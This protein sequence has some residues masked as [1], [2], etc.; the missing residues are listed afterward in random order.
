MM[1]STFQVKRNPWFQGVSVTADGTGVAALAGTAAVRLLADRV[2]LTAAL[3]SALARRNF[4]PVHD[5]GQVLVDVATVL[6]AGG[7]AIADIDTLRHQPL[8]GPVPSLATVW[9]PFD[10]ITP[11]ALRRGSPGPAPA[12]GPGWGPLPRRGP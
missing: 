7:E 5:R 9:R 11:A 1:R 2:G 8:W 10:E 3:S 6:A 12:P 4:V